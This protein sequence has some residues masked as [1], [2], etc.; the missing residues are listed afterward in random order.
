MTCTEL[1]EAHWLT[2]ALA[3]ALEADGCPELAQA[4]LSSIDQ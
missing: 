1:N 3:E 4:L 2:L